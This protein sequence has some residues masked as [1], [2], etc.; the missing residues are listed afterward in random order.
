MIKKIEEECKHEV[1]I[2]GYCADEE[3]PDE[4]PCV[5]CDKWCIFYDGKWVTEEFMYHK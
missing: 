2:L 5:N 3:A 4:G 1:P